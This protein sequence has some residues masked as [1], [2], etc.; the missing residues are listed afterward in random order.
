MARTCIFSVSLLLLPGC[1]LFFPTIYGPNAEETGS[2]ELKRFESEE[3]K[4]R[5]YVFVQGEVRTS[6]R[7]EYVDGLTVEKAIVLAGGFGARASKRKI[8]IRREGEP[9]LELN[10]VKLTDPVLPGDIIT[11]GVSIF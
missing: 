9:P 8:D 3:E 7:F 5:L 2:S 10:R 11:V 1:F 6:G 4:E